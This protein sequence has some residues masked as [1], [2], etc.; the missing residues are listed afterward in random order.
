MGFDSVKGDRGEPLS[1]QVR[2]PPEAQVAVLRQE[3]AHHDR[4][5][6][7]DRLGPRSEDAT[8]VNLLHRFIRRDLRALGST[9]H[10][11]ALLGAVLALGALP[12]S[13][14]AQGGAVPAGLRTNFMFGLSAHSSDGQVGPTYDNI[15]WMAN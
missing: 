8:E 3:A 7:G 5:P 9:A 4:G 2:R 13:A 1:P 10:T 11:I 12:R 15:S 6:G 14:A